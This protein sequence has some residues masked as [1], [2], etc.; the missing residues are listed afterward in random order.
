[1]F[2]SATSGRKILVRSERAGDYRSLGVLD[3]PLQVRETLFFLRKIRLDSSERL[4]RRSDIRLRLG[5]R[6]LPG[7]NASFQS[8][9]LR[10]V[11]GIR[12]SLILQQACE[13]GLEVGQL[14]V[15]FLPRDL[16]RSGTCAEFASWKP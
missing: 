1:M 2:L 6:L 16:K 9:P 10:L 11:E 13:L 8:L 14:V 12:G 5:D 7:L 15:R 3:G 4:F